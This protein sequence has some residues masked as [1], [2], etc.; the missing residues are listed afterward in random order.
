MTSPYLFPLGGT[1]GGGEGEIPENREYDEGTIRET[2]RG[3]WGEPGLRARV[4][5]Q[6]DQFRSC[7]LSVLTYSLIECVGGQGCYNADLIGLK[8]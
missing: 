5:S 7:F 2:T 1:S 4:L 8:F 6:S 3:V